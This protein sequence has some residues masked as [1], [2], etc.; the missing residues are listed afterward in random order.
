MKKEWQDILQ[1]DNRFR[2]M[3]LD[4]LKMD[5]KYYLG[6]GGRSANVLWAKDEA[7]HIELMKL[8]HNSFAEGDK[9]HYLTWDELLEFEKQLTGENS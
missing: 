4:R 5:C 9:P 1:S 7:D 6:N 3:F 8:V 2:Y